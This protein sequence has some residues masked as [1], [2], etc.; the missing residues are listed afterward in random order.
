MRCNASI[1]T[2]HPA[3]IMV[4]TSVLAGFLALG[5][6]STATLA[7]TSFKN[8]EVVETKASNFA[9][10]DNLKINGKICQ[11]YS[12]NITLKQCLSSWFQKLYVEQHGYKSYLKFCYDAGHGNCFDADFNYLDKYLDKL[13]CLH[14][15]SN[16]GK[17]D[18]HT[19]NK[20][21]NINWDKIAK[22]LAKCPNELN[23]DYE[24]FMLYNKNETEDE[25][26]N[27]VIIQAN[28]LEKLIEKYKKK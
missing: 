10:V 8:E 5:T 11:I 20:Y 26:L 27:E 23:L 3:N 25:V 2:M 13:I 9:N 19:L 28:E 15:H 18:Q 16:N 6:A 12:Y 1:S 21:G 7:I 4:K 17:S 24:V 14:L 22:S